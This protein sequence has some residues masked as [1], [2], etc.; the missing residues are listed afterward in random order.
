MR[1]VWAIV[2][3]AAAM[4]LLAYM[5]Y[6]LGLPGRLPGLK[7]GGARGTAFVVVDSGQSFARVTSRVPFTLELYI[8]VRV[9]GK[10]M[11]SL[12]YLKLP[13]LDVT[14]ALHVNVEAGEE[15]WLTVESISREPVPITVQLLAAPQLPNWIEVVLGYCDGRTY[16]VLIPLVG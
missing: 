12:C 11:A 15:G 8:R 5:L 6:G 7:R 1:K 14:T 2:A 16:T 13:D 10:G 4:A 3:V 9:L